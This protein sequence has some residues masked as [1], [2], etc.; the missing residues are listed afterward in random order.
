MS[1][2]FY[3]YPSFVLGAS[4]VLNVTMGACSPKGIQKENVSGSQMQGT[5]RQ[6]GILSDPKTPACWADAREGSGV[7]VSEYDF[8]KP[9]I[10]SKIKEQIVDRTNGLINPFPSVQETAQNPG[11]VLPSCGTEKSARIKLHLGSY[12]FSTAE[13]PAAEGQRLVFHLGRYFHNCE[14]LERTSVQESQT[15]GKSENNLQSSITPVPAKPGLERSCIIVYAGVLN[16]LAFQNQEVLKARVAATAL[17]EMMHAYGL[18]EEHL[19]S[20]NVHNIVNGSQDTNTC[21]PFER[22][23]DGN[24]VIPTSRS[25]IDYGNYDPQSIM[26]YCND[27]ITMES[28]VL[29][30]GDLQLLHFLY[31]PENRRPINKQATDSK[32]ATVSKTTAEVPTSGETTPVQPG[33]TSQDTGSRSG[34]LNCRSTQASAFSQNW[35]THYVVTGS[36]S[37][38]YKVQVTA[39]RVGD[40]KQEVVSWGEHPV[41]GATDPNWETAKFVTFTEGNSQFIIHRVDSAQP[42]NFVR[43]TLIC[44]N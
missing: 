36:L 28:V 26:N 43:A 9:I 16:H 18:H 12:P 39:T 35:Q 38:G 23:Q 1:F 20:S 10:E 33:T 25:A 44:N 15:A 42:K 31:S 19:H 22:N 30:T 41:V 2:P 37:L 40:T 7:S 21:D 32:P 6:E 4:V 17:H 8:L 3:L 27:P 14:R 13:Q 11:T 24:I 29:S 34:T 5:Y